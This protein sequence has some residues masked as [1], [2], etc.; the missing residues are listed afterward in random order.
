M[1]NIIYLNNYMSKELVEI[2]RNG[3][4]YSQAGNNKVMGI[5]QSLIENGCN[6]TILSSGLVNNRTGKLIKRYVDMNEKDIIYCPIIDFPLINTLSSIIFIYREILSIS[7]NVDIDN[8]IF[9]NYKP[10][11]AWAALLAKV[12]LKIPII[13]EFEDGYRNVPDISRIKRY[14]LNYTEKIIKPKVD[15]AILVTSKIEKD[16][17]DIPSVIVRGVSNESLL[18]SQKSKKG[19][20]TIKIMY[21][22][23][24]DEERGIKV[25]LESLKY[26]QNEFELIISGRGTLEGLVKCNDDKR[27]NYVGFIEYSDMIDY[28]LNSDILLNVQLSNH[29]FGDVSF[30]SKIFEYIS[31]GNL[32]VSSDVSDIREFCQGAFYIY[33]NDC[34]ISL[35]KKIDEAIKD[36]KNDNIFHNNKIK[37]LC[38]DNLPKN[39]GKKILDKVMK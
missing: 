18:K 26:T 23:G 34:P 22:G 35:A 8:I 9:Y 14:I 3:K 7:R 12:I 28:M 17:R 19:N 29:S 25:L 21:S 39:I 38:I 10:E 36:I 11:V 20:D 6:V 31:T 5:R 27:I 33:S 15:G 16:Y 4:I 37:E 2:R 13:I 1:K 32:I 24:I 30:P